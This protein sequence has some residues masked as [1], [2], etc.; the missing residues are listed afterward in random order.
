MDECNRSV[1]SVTSRSTVQCKIVQN[2][3][4]QCRLCSML[5]VA[6]GLLVHCSVKFSEHSI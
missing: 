3:T 6:C 1:T 5:N 4:A 2:S